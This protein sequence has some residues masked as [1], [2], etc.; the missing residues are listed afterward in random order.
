M[1]YRFS[2]STTREMTEVEWQRYRERYMIL[3]QELGEGVPGIDWDELERTG[4][5]VWRTGETTTTYRLE[6]LM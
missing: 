2:L 3:C 6:K 1:R 5:T 4:K